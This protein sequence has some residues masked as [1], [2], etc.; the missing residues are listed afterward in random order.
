M[1]KVRVEQK[2][3][4]MGYET[5][6]FRPEMNEYIENMYNSD[7]VEVINM[8]IFHERT[9]FSDDGIYRVVFMIRDIEPVT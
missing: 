9:R 2:S 3:F 8:N 6:K 4:F 7:S 1:G 5:D